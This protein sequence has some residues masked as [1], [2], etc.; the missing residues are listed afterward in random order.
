MPCPYDLA[1]KDLDPSGARLGKAAVGLVRFSGSGFL[2]I[3]A[4]K[5]NDGTTDPE[6]DP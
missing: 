2:L 1:G 4:E 5:T 6:E 3:S